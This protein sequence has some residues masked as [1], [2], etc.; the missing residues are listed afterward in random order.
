MSEMTIGEIAR[1]AGLRPSA[2]RYYE[3]IGL[4]P[5]PRRVSG[6]RR[7]DPDVLKLL[8]GVRFAQRAGFTVGEIKRL[9]YG[10]PSSAA[11]AERWRALAERKLS[12]L[13]DLIRG[14]HE[15]QAVLREGIRCGCASFEE[16]T[17]VATPEA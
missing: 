17:L 1:H 6:A 5:R 7:Y 2:L 13:D 4:L 14:A 10:F 3:S 15:M 12:E 16:C 8:A 9:F 11:P